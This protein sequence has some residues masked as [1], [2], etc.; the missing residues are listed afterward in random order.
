VVTFC[1]PRCRAERRAERLHA[2]EARDTGP[3]DRR[4]GDPMMLRL[5]IRLADRGRPN[6]A[7]AAA[8]AVHPWPDL[9][10]PPRL[11]LA[12]ALSNDLVA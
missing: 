10:C 7:A 4:L 6:A 9:R 12:T 5:F 1:C 8:A 2:R 11:R 3:K